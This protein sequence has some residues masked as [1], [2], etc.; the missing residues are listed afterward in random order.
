VTKTDKLRL[1][2]WMGQSTCS[3]NLNV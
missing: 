1:A 2:F 3:W